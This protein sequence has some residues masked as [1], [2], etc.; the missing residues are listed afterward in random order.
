MHRYSIFLLSVLALCACAETTS[1]WPPDS[2]DRLAQENAV[3]AVVLDSL[4]AS[5]DPQQLVISETTT[6]RL[7]LSDLV[8]EFWHDISSIPG[9]ERSAYKDF[10]VINRLPRTLQRLEG[11][12]APVVLA[13]RAVLDSLPRDLSLPPP[14]APNQDWSEY[15]RAFYQLFPGSIGVTTFSRV[16]FS[17]D[18]RQALVIVDHGCGSLCGS[19]RIILLQNENGRWRIVVEQSTWV[20]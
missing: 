12:R 20:S 14:G 6:E 10:Q 11:V 4:F 18:L 13:T 15:W 19:G 8:P 1:L 2:A 16:G 7:T 9:L 5:R 17:P 3:Y